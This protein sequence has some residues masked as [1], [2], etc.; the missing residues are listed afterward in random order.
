MNT[1]LIAIIIILCSL[2]LV[3]LLT[4]ALRRRIS[5]N[6]ENL[7]PQ[8]DAVIAENRRVEQ[9]ARDEFGRQREESSRAATALREEVSTNINTGLET[10]LNR[11]G[12]AQQTIE[13]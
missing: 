7:R 13:A 4:L 10:L 6:P 11:Q 2:T 5:I 3:T 1:Y 12:E 9:T 8:F